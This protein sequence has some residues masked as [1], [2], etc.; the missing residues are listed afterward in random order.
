MTATEHVEFVLVGTGKDIFHLSFFSF[1]AVRVIFSFVFAG[2]LELM[3]F[4]I[5]GKL[6][7]T[8]R[9]SAL[10]NNLERLVPSCRRRWSHQY[11]TPRCRKSNSMNLL[12]VYIEN[13]VKVILSTFKLFL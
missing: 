8:T 4:I 5:S 1:I 10:I 7:P 3:V 12:F 9:H 2:E 13:N 6:I 11:L